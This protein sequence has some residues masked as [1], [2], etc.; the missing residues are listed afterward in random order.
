M[1]AIDNAVPTERR[2]LTWPAWGWSL[3]GVLAVWAV[4][5]AVRP[6]APL[7]PLTQALSLA[8]FLVLVALGQMLVITL[9]PGNIDVSVGTIVS[10]TSYVSVAVGATAGPVVGLAAAAGAGVAAGAVSVAAILLLRVPP[11]IA[12]LATSLVVTSATLLLADAAR[13]G[14]D[15]ALRSFVNA[16]VLGIP[17]IALLVVLVTVVIWFLLRHTRLGL[18]IIAVGQSERAAERAGLKVVAVTATAYLVSAGFAGLVGG[19]LAAFISPSTQLGTSYM[20]DS[21]AVV[22]IGGTLISGGRP[23]ATGAWTGALFFVLLSGLLN[24][25][26]WSVGAQNVLKG[27]LV[28]LVVI[29]A[30]AATGTGRT[31]IRRLRAS[32]TPGAPQAASTTTTQKEPIHG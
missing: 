12:T 5:V 9:G 19:L 8:P 2:R 22:V 27:V 4:I 3:I 13:G 7:D 1:S 10:M 32:L 15:P 18:S 25:V 28:V 31:S 16:K 6:G 24:L 23:V 26:G 20:L 29:V 11:I 21:I 17:L 14:A 30:S